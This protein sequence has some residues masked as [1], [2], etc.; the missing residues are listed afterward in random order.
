MPDERGPGF[1]GA[2]WRGYP[3]AA[4][5]V[6]PGGEVSCARAVELTHRASP[7]QNGDLPR[8]KG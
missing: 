7:A 6:V 3:T 8:L 5:I 1:F 4:A 2:H